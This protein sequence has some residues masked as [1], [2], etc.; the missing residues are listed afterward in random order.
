MSWLGKLT[1]FWF[2]RNSN[3]W[4]KHKKDAKRRDTVFFSF[5]HCCFC[6]GVIDRCLWRISAYFTKNRLRRSL[7]FSQIGH[8]WAKKVFHCEFISINSNEYC[9]LTLITFYQ[10]S[11]PIPFMAPMILCATRTI[12]FF[13][14]LGNKLFHFQNIRWWHQLVIFLKYCWLQN[15]KK[16][17]MWINWLVKCNF[18]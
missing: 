3:N 7:I 18:G 10:K 11:S 13:G 8:N 6:N 14:N 4:A 12:A 9:R 17:K 2:G 16:R 1:R 5:V 15:M